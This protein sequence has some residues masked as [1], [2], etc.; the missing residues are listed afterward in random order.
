[1]FAG[2]PRSPQSSLFY[3]EGYDYTGP[4][5]HAARTYVKPSVCLNHGTH[6]PT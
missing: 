4:I 6:A 5:I 2:L 1:M 3:E